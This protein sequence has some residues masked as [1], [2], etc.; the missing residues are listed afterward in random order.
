MEFHAISNKKVHSG[1]CGVHRSNLVQRIKYHFKTHFY[2][3]SACIIKDLEVKNILKSGDFLCWYLTGEILIK[4][5]LLVGFKLILCTQIILFS[6][7]CAAC[8]K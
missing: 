2:I 1:K 8:K 5:H 4:I 6:K 3:L 7:D